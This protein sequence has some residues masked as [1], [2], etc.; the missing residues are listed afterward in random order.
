MPR[1]RLLLL[2]GVMAAAA[3]LPGLRWLVRRSG[4]AQ[5]QRSQPPPNGIARL[6]AM[7]SRAVSS[8]AIAVCQAD[9]LAERSCPWS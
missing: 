7:D 4:T 3:Y 5:V 9:T 6:D 2:T 1:Y 8:T